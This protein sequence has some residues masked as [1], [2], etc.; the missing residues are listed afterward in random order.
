MSKLYQRADRIEIPASMT[1]LNFYRHIGYIGD[2]EQEYRLENFPKKSYYNNTDIY[3]IRP[4]IN[5]IK[6]IYKIGLKE[7]YN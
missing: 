2:D 3:N 7:I 1:A 6:K 4:Y 5:K